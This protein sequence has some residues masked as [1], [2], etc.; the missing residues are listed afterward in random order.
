MAAR[1]RHV[2]RMP[3]STLGIAR[4]PP[5]SDVYVPRHLNQVN[6]PVT[7]RSGG[8][9]DW[10]AATS[11]GVARYRQWP[12]GQDMVATAAPHLPAGRSAR[13]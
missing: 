3:E 8:G 1:S 9:T 11:T 6:E 10:S 13:L 2:F 5:Q 12:P 4:L 7:G